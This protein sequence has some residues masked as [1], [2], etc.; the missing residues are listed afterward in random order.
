MSEYISPFVSSYQIKKNIIDENNYTEYNSSTESIETYFNNTSNK[1]FVSN[2]YE[3]FNDASE[4][5]DGVRATVIN[6]RSWN[7]TL[8]YTGEGMIG[9]DTMKGAKKNSNVSIGRMYYHNGEPDYMYVLKRNTDQY[10]RSMQIRYDENHMLILFSARNLSSAYGY[11][12]AFVIIKESYK[13]IDYAYKTDQNW[14]TEPVW[15]GFKDYNRDGTYWTYNT[16]TIPNTNLYARSYNYTTYAFESRLI[17][18]DDFKVKKFMYH[19]KPRSNKI[20]DC[21]IKPIV[22]GK[23][24]YVL[25]QNNLHESLNL[26]KKY[27]FFIEGIPNELVNIRIK[28]NNTSEYYDADYDNTNDYAL[29]HNNTTY[30]ISS[31]DYP[32][33]N[34]TINNLTNMIR[35]KIEGNISTLACAL[36]PENLKIICYRD[37]IKIGKDY[38]IDNRWSYIIPNLDANAEYDIILIDE[39]KKIEW[40]V[41]SKR[42]PLAYIS[43]EEISAPNIIN[44]IIIYNPSTFPILQWEYDLNNNTNIDESKLYFSNIE[45]SENIIE[46]NTDNIFSENINGNSVILI[47]RLKY[48]YYMIKVKYKNSIKFSKLLSYNTKSP[49]NLKA[50]FNE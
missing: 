22:L 19:N 5:D 18:Q 6:K 50:T 48:N 30:H 47:D 41:H 20:A 27:N 8:S 33:Y 4:F 23:I 13:M 7:I 1:L 43:E 46:T 17:I 25:N 28:N 37:G 12:F 10:F 38:Y 36:N 14:G 39:S 45:F 9:I 2:G 44:E 32:Y 49:I 16:I 15:F 42:K 24:N 3:T 21:F 29:D 31:S 34:L 40:K 35:G 11:K 26:Y